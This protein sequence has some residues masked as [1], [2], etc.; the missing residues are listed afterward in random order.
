MCALLVGGIYRES[1]LTVIVA[2]QLSAFAT[3]IS[4]FCPYGG[5]IALLS[6]LSLFAGVILYFM[7]VPWPEDFDSVTH[8]A[9]S[10]LNR[11]ISF[12]LNRRAFAPLL[13]TLPS[14]S[15]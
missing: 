7:C 2:A 13:P 3:G 11:N 6:I 12:G 9:A 14:S 10:E 5:I 8:D 1:F 4:S 15:T